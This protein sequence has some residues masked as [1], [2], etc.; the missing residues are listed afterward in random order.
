MFGLSLVRPQS[1]CVGAFIAFI[2]VGLL[3]GS[4]VCKIKMCY[5]MLMND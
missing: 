5:P 3:P 1:M 2:F 4:P